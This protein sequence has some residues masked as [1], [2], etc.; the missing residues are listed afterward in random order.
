MNYQERDGAQDNLTEDVE[1]KKKS[2]VEIKL[3][4][5]GFSVCVSSEFYGVL[6]YFKN[7]FWVIYLKTK[8]KYYQIKGCCC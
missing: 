7:F 4:M 6:M 8:K 2:R 5:W 3:N 1:E